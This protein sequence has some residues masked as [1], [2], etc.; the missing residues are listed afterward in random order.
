MS[1]LNTLS[2]AVCNLPSL[3]LKH[4]G[5]IKGSYPFGTDSILFSIFSNFCASPEWIKN[6][7]CKCL[8]MYVKKSRTDRLSL[9]S[10]LN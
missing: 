6:S 3:S 7:V 4:A 1:F 2:N 9:K 10:H 8:L 5:K